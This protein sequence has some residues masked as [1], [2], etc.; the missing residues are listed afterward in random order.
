[1]FICHMRLC[2][3]DFN[4]VACDFVRFHLIKTL[5]FTNILLVIINKVYIRWLNICRSSPL[6][7]FL[8]KGVLTIYSKFTREYPYRSV[9]SK[10]WIPKCDFR[11]VNVHTE[12]WNH[13]SAK[14]EITLRHG[15]CPVNLLHIF[16]TPFLK[17]TFAG[18][19]LYLQSSL[20][21]FWVYNE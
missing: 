7:V 19:L 14:C 20:L 6:E 1:M 2:L 3:A 18:L 12:V 9:I 4:L 13:T 16:R 11:S 5:S 15:C 8:G 21:S 17:N 10:V